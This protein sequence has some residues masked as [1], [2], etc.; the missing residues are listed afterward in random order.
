MEDGEEQPAFL[1]VAETCPTGYIND[2]WGLNR[3]A[4]DKEG[5]QVSC[6]FASVHRSCV[7]V[8]SRGP[9]SKE[10]RS[11]WTMGS[12]SGLGGRGIP[13]TRGGSRGRDQKELVMKEKN[14][15]SS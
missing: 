3:K 13:S 7:S 8:Y 5:A 2:P 4:K 10:R 9:S 14:E 11:C 1:F 12:N 15:S 6:S